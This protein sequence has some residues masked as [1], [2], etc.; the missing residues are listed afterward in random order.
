[1]ATNN[2]NYTDKVVATSENEKWSWFKITKGNA[3]Q[4]TPA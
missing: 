1:M 4:G 2:D 3:A